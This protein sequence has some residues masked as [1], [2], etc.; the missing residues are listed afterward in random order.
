MIVRLPPIPVSKALQLSTA[1]MWALG[2]ALGWLAYARP[3]RKVLWGLGAVLASITASLLAGGS[4]VPVVLYDLFSQMPLVQWLAFPLV[5]V[6]AA[7]L[8]TRR[9]SIEAGLSVVVGLGVVFVSAIAVLQYY[10]NA[11]GVFGSS[12]YSTT[13]LAPLIPVASALAVSRSGWQRKAL[14]AASIYIA[15]GLGFFAGST[16]AT[17]AAV[18][19]VAIAIAI[20]PL[21][22]TALSRD[23]ALSLRLVRYGALAVAGILAAG[24]LFA[25]VPVLSGSIVNAN[26]LGRFDKNIVSRAYLWEGAQSMVAAR[27]VLGFGPSGYRVNAVDYLSPETFQFGPDFAGSID[28]TVYSPQSPH[29]A[30]WEIATRLGIVGL[31]AF[32]ALF[33][34]W[35][36]VLAEKVRVRGTPEAELRVGLGAGFV[37]A[38]FALLVNPVLFA[39]GLFAAVAAG[40]A[41]APEFDVDARTLKP[42]SSWFRPLCLA[43]GM[44]VVAMAVWLGVGESQAARAQSDDAAA[45]IVAYE[46]VLGFLPGHPMTQRRLLE[47]KLLVAADQSQA[48]A[49]QAAVDQAPAYMLDYAPNAVNFA[50]HSLAQAERTGRTDL[51]WETRQLD[52][53]A[54]ELP[55]IPSLVAERLHLAVLMGDSAAVEAALPDARRWGGP[56][57]YTESYLTAAEKLL[58]P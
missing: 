41:V 19:S 15:V 55:P 6:L 27:P 58:V 56:Y 20:H 5:F 7:G 47:S 31:I 54:A 44:L 29:S 17:I 57:P 45:S 51:A 23:A 37:V 2:F 10:T 26:S 46:K 9:S 36:I 3:D 4:F 14:Y 50:A 22:A 49:A 42:S 48:D 30:L 39:I 11:Y 24:L 35:G 1:G 34:L 12:A 43:V 16:M 32:G 18:F 52:S 13:A 25:Q 38:V 21:T 8:V 53:A 33:V 28:P 40:L